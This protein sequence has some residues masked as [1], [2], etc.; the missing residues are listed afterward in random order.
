MKILSGV[1]HKLKTAGDYATTGLRLGNDW[2]SQFLL[3]SMLPRLKLH[4]LLG[5][6]ASRVFTAEVAIGELRRPV[7]LREQDIFILHEVLG[8]SPYMIAD[9]Y[10]SPPRCIIDLGAHIGLATLQF[11]AAFPEAIIHSYEPDP[12]NFRLLELNTQGLPSVILHH[13]GVGTA[14]AKAILYVS[15]NRHSSTSLKRPY[16]EAA[17]HEVECMVKPLDA[18]IHE[19]G[20][21]VDLIK[22]DIEGVEHQVFS[23]SNFVHQVRFLVGEMKALPSEI[24]QFVTLFPQHQVSIQRI[25]KR[26]HFMQLRRDRAPGFA[27]G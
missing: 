3:A 27:N 20:E 1:A 23:R 15:P 7:Y 5:L 9:F 18:L 14:W 4:S 13:E 25:G 6:N 16:D 8:H 17:V 12:E 10:K 22:F 21:A 26:M 24:D 19:A 11:K 2:R